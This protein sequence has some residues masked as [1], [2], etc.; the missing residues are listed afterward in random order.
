MPQDSWM[1]LE[2]IPD[3]R[4]DY[5]SGGF[6][7]GHKAVQVSSMMPVPRCP[8]S[9][10]WQIP[11]TLIIQIKQEKGQHFGP[12]RGWILQA[13]LRICQK[14]IPPP[15]PARKECISFTLPHNNCRLYS[16]V[17]LL[18]DLRRT[19]A[20]FTRCWRD[21]KERKTAKRKLR[22]LRY[23]EWNYWEIRS[24]MLYF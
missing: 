21:W 20:F 23:K 10:G 3:L 9:A 8:G 13:L 14:Y 11:D 22:K 24:Q 15:K 4:V 5:L 18:S 12:E 7:A 19:R 16:G 6:F 1:S 2:W 17:D